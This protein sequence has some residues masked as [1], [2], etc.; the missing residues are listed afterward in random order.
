[1]LD[2]KFLGTCACDFSERLKTDLKDKLD[3]DARRSSSMLI[4]GEILVDCGPHTLDSL[5]I[6]SIS[7]DKI[8]SVV[9]TH[10]HDDH[11]N[12]DNILAIAKSKSA[13]LKL[14]V[15]EDADIDTSCGIEIIKMKPFAEYCL[16]SEITVTGMDANHDKDAFPQHLL[17][18]KN[19]K[20]LFYGCDGAWLRNTTYYALYN[21]NLD[22]MVLD[23]TCGDYMGDYRIGE[24]NSI[25]MLRVMLPSLRTFGVINE[26]TKVYFSHLAPSLHASHEETEKIA[27]ELG[28]NVA[29]DGLEIQL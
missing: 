29:Y 18:N 15:R 10:L 21:T 26:K 12:M 25:P 16:N 14:Y 1:M 6:M 11:F 4:D 13:P 7:L 8:S 3:K 20:K 28:A 2:I 5:R 22:M 19:G 9:I 27:G 24:H 23:C 17:F